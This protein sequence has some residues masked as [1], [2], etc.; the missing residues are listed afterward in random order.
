MCTLEA[1]L[2][3]YDRFF[4]VFSNEIELNELMLENI[5]SQLLIKF[6]KWV[7]VEVHVRFPPHEELAM[8]YCVIHVCAHCDHPNYPSLLDTHEFMEVRIEHKMCSILR[9]LFCSV[10]VDDVTFLPSPTGNTFAKSSV[11]KK[12]RVV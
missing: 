5:F 6:F 7:M 10:I 8:Q 3:C 9:E 1:H 2:Q 11:G 12:Y 4:E